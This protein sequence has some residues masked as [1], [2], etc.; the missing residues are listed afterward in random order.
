[1]L[2][3]SL[4]SHWTNL[5]PAYDPTRPAT[6]SDRP[7]GGFGASSNASKSVVSKK[8]ERT[9]DNKTHAELRALAKGAVLSLVPHKILYADLVR[10]G[11]DPQILRELYGEL[12]LKVELEQAQPLIEEPGQQ[13]VSLVSDPPATSSQQFGAALPGDAVRIVDAAVI[14]PPPTTSDTTTNPNVAS[15]LAPQPA[16]LDVR[17]QQAAPS[18]SLERKDR[19]AQLLAAK[20]GRPTPSPTATATT[21][22]EE[23]LAP[24]TTTASANT[25]EAVMIPSSLQTPSINQPEHI[26]PPPTARMNK[27]EAR[28][29]LVKQKMEQLKREAQARDEANRLQLP[30][31]R[32]GTLN[33]SNVVEGS[34]QTPQSGAVTPVI[35]GKISL[36]QP[37]LTSP[38]PGL[39]MSSLESAGPYASA[40]QSSPFQAMSSSTV[41]AKHPLEPHATAVIS[42]GPS[43]KP[44]ME[45]SLQPAPHAEDQE[46]NLD[47]QSEGEVIEESEADAMA[48]DQD[49]GTEL[50]QD[51]QLSETPADATSYPDRPAADHQAS[52]AAL[53][54]PSPNVPVSD[55]LYR[56]KKS[57]IETMRRK[58]AEMEQRN[59]LKRTRD[60]LESPGSSKPTT[61]PL[62]RDDHQLSSSPTNHHA[63][64]NGSRQALG[65]RTASKLTRAQLQERAALLKADLL[66][67]RVQRQQ[68]LQ[69]G[70]PD[71]NAE[72]RHTETRLDDSRRELAQVRVQLQNLH[73]ELDRLVAQEKE[74]DDEVARFEQHLKEGRAGQK[75]YSNELQQ[76]KLEKLAE[77]EAAL[78]QQE[79]ETSLQARPPTSA[80]PQALPGLDSGSL[81]DQGL[82]NEDGQPSDDVPADSSSAAPTYAVDEEGDT[83]MQV[84][85]DNESLLV[86]Q[87]E[88][89]IPE[90]TE[91][92]PTP[93]ATVEHEQEMQ[94]DGIEQPPT[95]SHVE[96]PAVEE[97]QSTDSQL[98]AA[99]DGQ[100]GAG[101]MEIS[102]EPE[103]YQES[104]ESLPAPIDTA[105]E[106][107][108]EALDVNDDSD[109][110]ASM[111]GSDDEEDEYEPAEADTIV[112]MQ[113]SDDEEEYDP[114]A[115]PVDSG[116]PTTA[117]G[118]GF[119]NY[120][121]PPVHIDVTK[122]VAIPPE[123]KVSVNDISTSAS[124]DAPAEAESNIALVSEVPVNTQDD[125]ESR[126]QLTE[127]DSITRPAPG[128]SREAEAVFLLD[129]RSA[130]TV[131]Y[132]PY[133]TPLSSF[134]S[135]RFHSDFNDNVKSGYRSLTYSNNIDSTRPLCPTEL[136]GQVCAEPTCEGQHFSQLGLPDEKILVQMSSASDIKDKGAKDE[137]HAG[138][139]AVIAE[140]R[141][142][143][144]KDF[145]KV[146]DALSKYRR[147]FFAW[148]EEREGRE[149]EQKGQ[150]YVTADEGEI[151][152]AS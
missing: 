106:S 57:E 29:E 5:I 74:L 76:I 95:L 1:M 110:S 71:L 117:A 48:I 10:E 93:A 149:V 18:P 12:G 128:Q 64:L 92:A 135:Y 62:A 102:P 37:A 141:A 53:Q 80:V 151:T 138:L 42:Q 7:S 144:V 103:E 98:Q 88:D 107:T 113:Q 44:K 47:Y 94:R 82:P 22:R 65:A 60:Q 91:L 19:I 85:D 52:T 86:G 119:E 39:F 111:S 125:L 104:H 132:V 139:K 55:H 36:S 120:Q 75:Q 140:L 84:E 23:T 112:P 83:E 116:T 3:G 118:D 8:M 13:A 51:Y 146:A 38:I 108:E 100:L 70:L 4:N 43:K 150:E 87:I 6:L 34:N 123:G 115:A 50:Q 109:G 127:A 142:N 69:K 122:N 130:P 16:I 45:E 81:V 133:K 59:K 136:S 11:I 66:K 143:D 25:N 72:V 46:D 28:T 89:S 67:Q 40:S 41:P 134:K 63:H 26:A 145:E 101:K 124:E 79:L 126:A 32:A 15:D 114:E 73:S 58:I 78:P 105:Q 131:H 147:D 129:G 14:P 61:P 97:A 90:N 54:T 35:A 31:A 96:D 24:S 30:R 20:A 152:E 21:V 2:T 33:R 27:S 68:V 9:Y 99:L 137:F 121:R 148:G 77:E 49:T 17:K 56:A